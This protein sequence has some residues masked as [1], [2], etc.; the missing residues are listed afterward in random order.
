MEKDQLCGRSRARPQETTRRR[1][2]P[3]S[4]GQCTV[5]PILPLSPFHITTTA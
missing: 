3:A 4:P 2:E 1:R 5:S